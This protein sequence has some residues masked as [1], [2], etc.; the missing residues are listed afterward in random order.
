MTDYIQAI[1]TTDT[2]E[3]AVEIANSLIRH[4]HAAC[5]QI[6]GPIQS[7]YWWKE[8]IETAAE[9]LCIIKT[10]RDHFEH[11]EAT[12]RRIHTYEVPEI[13][14]T[15]IIEGNEGYLAWLDKALQ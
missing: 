3:N 10:R 2:K 5:V 8:E 7:T 13:I 4:R 1:T 9:W 14:A 15:P 11:V 12:I 6:V